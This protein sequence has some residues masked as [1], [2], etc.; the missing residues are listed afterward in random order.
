M[1]GGS[2]MRVTSRPFISPN[3]A[4][5]PMPHRMASGAGTPRSAANFVITM[6]PSAMTMPQDRSM[7][8]VRMISVC[9]MAMTP[10]TITC[11][12]ISE[13]FSPLKK[14]SVVAPKIAQAMISAMKGPSWPMGGSFMSFTKV[15]GA[16]E[17]TPRN[18]LRR[19]AGVAPWGEA[20]AG[21]C[22]GGSIY[23]PSTGRHRS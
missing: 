9:P 17:Q 21:R 5:T 15:G 22:G 2:L 7:P 10:T 14:R 13:K 16:F 18:R 4:V 20:A 19:A 11:C 6:L 8:A 23:C 1:N 12:R 3:K